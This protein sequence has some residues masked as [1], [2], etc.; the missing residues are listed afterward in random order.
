MGYQ[1]RIQKRYQRHVRTFRPPDLSSTPIRQTKRV[2]VVD[3]KQTLKIN[4]LAMHKISIRSRYRPQSTKVLHFD[5]IIHAKSER[6]NAET[7]LDR[8]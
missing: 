8:D 5:R 6:R 7:R 3:G 1:T 2:T 4:R